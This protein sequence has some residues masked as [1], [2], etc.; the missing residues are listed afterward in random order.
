[1][2]SAPTALE[3]SRPGAEYFRNVDAAREGEIGVGATSWR[4]N[5]K[6]L[7]LPR[8]RRPPGRKDASAER[9]GAISADDGKQPGR[10]EAEAERKKRDL[11]PGAIR[12]VAYQVVGNFERRGIH[13]TG[14]A[15]TG[16]EIA[17]PSAIL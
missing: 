15:N 7:P 12:R 2:E 1:P 17:E 13:R 14:P 9:H 11:E 3:V 6:G 10:E 4:R 8:H 5:L 16:I